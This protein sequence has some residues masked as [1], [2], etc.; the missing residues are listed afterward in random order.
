[1]VQALTVTGHVAVGS[2]ILAT[3]VWLAV[4]AARLCV[5]EREANRRGQPTPG[6]SEE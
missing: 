6:V 1:M 3:S 2:L 5:V 4:R